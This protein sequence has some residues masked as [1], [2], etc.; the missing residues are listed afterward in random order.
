MM[1]PSDNN[2]E[3][4]KVKRK[5]FDWIS[6]PDLDN[7][8]P[9]QRLILDINWEKSPLG[10]IQKWPTQLKRMVMLIVQD[11][12]PAII[13]W[14]EEATVLY[15]EAYITIVGNKH[16]A[17]QGGDPRIGLSDLWPSIEPLLNDQRDDF[18]PLVEANTLLMLDRSGFIEETY[19]SWRLIPIIGE[20]GCVGGSYATV[21]ETTSEVVNDRR[22]AVVQ[23]LAR[24][25]TQASSI[26]ELWRRI[27]EGLSIE[28]AEK[29]L[30]LAMLYSTQI[31]KGDFRRQSI[32][33]SSLPSV[34]L[35]CTLEGVVGVTPGHGLAPHVLDLY[36]TNPQHLGYHLR[37]AMNAM[38]PV[39]IEIPEVEESLEWRGYGR[40]THGVVCPIVPRGANTVVA[41]LALA[42]NPRRPYDEGYQRFIHLL[43]NQVTQP[44][45]SAIILRDEVENRQNI[46]RQEAIDRDQLSRELSASE[47]RFARF[48][49]RAPM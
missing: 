2:T 33:T 12:S 10:P 39:V 16:P 3:P 5:V 47:T 8:T 45:L 13:Y 17:L 32:P 44:Q 11:P 22:L 21:L 37:M 4:V 6:N 41:F 19:H 49:S 23:N 30:P 46:A 9:F 35:D 20:D 42:L 25:L 26:K 1:E 15:N 36:D 38:A 31:V 27:I 24:V 14:G 40:A 18:Q 29:D 28:A 48:A 7:I 43:T 34:P